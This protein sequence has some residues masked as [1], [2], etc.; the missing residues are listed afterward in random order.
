MLGIEPLEH[1]ERPFA[2]PGIA[3]IRTAAEIVVVT[4]R[5]SA[6]P[7]VERLFSLIAT[8]KT[9]TQLSTGSI[10]LFISAVTPQQAITAS[11][12]PLQLL[13][14][15]ESNRFSTDVGL[16]EVTGQP[17][18]LEMSI[19]PQNAKVAAKVTMT[20]GAREFHTLKQLMKSVGLEGAYNARVS[21]RVIG[22][23]GAATAYAA[24]TDLYTRDTTFMPAQ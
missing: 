21:V 6:F 4:S 15:E 20:L 2:I 5:R 7:L 24:V 1:D 16:A 22:G 11:S 14:V 18:E 23:A 13:Q 10:G 3:R 12:R 17:V 9:Y 8:A 19:I